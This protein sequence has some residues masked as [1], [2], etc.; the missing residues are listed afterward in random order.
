M[1]LAPC[2]FCG[3]KFTISSVHLVVVLAGVSPFVTVET[4]PF[5]CTA[6]GS[7]HWVPIG[8]PSNL[9]ALVLGLF[10]SVGNFSQCLLVAARFGCMKVLLLCPTVFQNFI[11]RKCPGGLPWMPPWPFSGISF[12][13]SW[14]ISVIFR[15]PFLPVFW[16]RSWFLVAVATVRLV[17]TQRAFAVLI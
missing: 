11:H 16:S 8:S 10:M 9:D 15:H 1:K 2:R 12:W 13:P 7:F 6:L 14:C 4:L 5:S 17:I 3:K